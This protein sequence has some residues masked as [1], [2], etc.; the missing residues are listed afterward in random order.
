MQ[1]CCPG[2]AARNRVGVEPAATC[3]RSC[4]DM[5]YVLRPMDPL[6]LGRLHGRRL[7]RLPAEPVTPRELV[8]DRRDARLVLRVRA[9]FVLD[10][11]G[12]TEVE[13]GRHPGTVSAARP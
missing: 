10:R 8:F 13:T 9:G 3:C 5:L 7:T 2:A 4:A 12:V 6:E 1:G 11:G